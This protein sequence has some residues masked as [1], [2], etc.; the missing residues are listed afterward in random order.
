[1]APMFRARG[2]GPHDFC[3]TALRMVLLILFFSLFSGFIS[4]TTGKTGRQNLERGREEE[5]VSETLGELRVFTHAELSADC[6]I[7]T[8]SR[9]GRKDWE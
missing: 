8:S 6:R 7:W 5:S 4:S 9:Y 3:Q 1:M 2:T